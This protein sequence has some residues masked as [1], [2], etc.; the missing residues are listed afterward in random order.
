[1]SMFGLIGKITA[2]P[3][4]RPE[5]LALLTR[6][7]GNMPG[8]LSYVIA[9]DPGDEVT[10]WVTEAWQSEGDHRASLSLPEVKSAIAAAMPLI[11]GFD[12]VAKTQPVG[13][14]GLVSAG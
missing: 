9:Q 11:A 7:S 8:C 3:G 4:A 6:G 5:L 10:I 2:K 12:T 14:H 1:M 13:G